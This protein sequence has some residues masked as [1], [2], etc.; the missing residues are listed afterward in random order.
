LS[1]KQTTYEGTILDNIIDDKVNKSNSLQNLSQERIKNIIAEEY[2][3]KTSPPIT[4]NPYSNVK[5]DFSKGNLEYKLRTWKEYPPQAS[6]EG[7]NNPNSAWYRLPE[8]Y[9]SLYGENYD[10]K[11]K[12]KNVRS[13]IDSVMNK[14]G[15]P[16]IK[17]K[18]GTGRPSYVK[19]GHGY[20]I[21][22]SNTIHNTFLNSKKVEYGNYLDKDSERLY[23]TPTSDVDT[24]NVY[25]KDL[26]DD[27]IAEMG[28]AMQYRNP[29]LPFNDPYSA[30]VRDSIFVEGRLQRDKY[31]DWEDSDN[32]GTY[33]IRH[34]H[35]HSNPMVNLFNYMFNP[36]PTM[37]YEAHEINE[38]LLTEEISNLIDYFSKLN[39]E[40]KSKF[41]SNKT[42]D[43]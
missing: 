34:Q 2:I 36:N 13:A 26:Y 4:K 15:N 14:Y 42:G 39:P 10:Y 38:N 9:D 43:F 24:L 6:R 7:V 41:L 23:I 12:F 8:L 28:H 16:Y 40:Q 20:G 22:P 1:I 21:P 33:G 27:T 25:E 35:D 19:A 31:G 3:N 11:N 37:E 30:F 32:R 17:V 5:G 29:N 18:K